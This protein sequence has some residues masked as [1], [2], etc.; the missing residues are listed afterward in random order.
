LQFVIHIFQIEIPVK[1][2]SSLPNR[3]DRR[4]EHD[5]AR[6]WECRYPWQL[7]ERLTRTLFVGPAA[8]Y[9]ADVGAAIADARPDLMI[10]SMFCLGGVVSAETAGIPFNVLLPNI[11]LLPAPG[12]PPLWPRPPA[13]T[14]RARSATRPRLERLQ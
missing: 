12:L 14:E 10:C 6:D 2:E 4:P 13:G 5:P 7:V 11:Y 3:P 9:A 8:A 1:W